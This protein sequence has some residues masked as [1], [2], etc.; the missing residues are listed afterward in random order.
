MLFHAYLM[1]FL[2]PCVSL[3]CRYQHSG[4]RGLLL[5]CRTHTNSNYTGVLGSTI[6]SSHV[7]NQFTGYSGLDQEMYMCRIEGSG[8][9][10]E[11]NRSDSLE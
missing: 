4:F 10:M 8:L 6:I 7:K 1:Q 5:S 11:Q 9:Q 2:L 3:S